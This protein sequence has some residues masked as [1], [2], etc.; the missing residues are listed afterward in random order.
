MHTNPKARLDTI[1]R[2]GLF[3]YPGNLVRHLEMGTIKNK[4]FFNGPI[5]KQGLFVVDISRWAPPLFIFTRAK[6][7][8]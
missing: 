2:P 7:P 1:V 6:I 3:H 4:A 8:V 5:K